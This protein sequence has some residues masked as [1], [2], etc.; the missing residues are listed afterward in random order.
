MKVYLETSIN[1]Y[2]SKVEELLL[3]DEANNN[4]MLGLLER[5]RNNIGI[6]TNGIR[7]GVVEED[8]EVIYAFMQTPPN[9]WILAKID[10][11]Q[12]NIIP[13]I[14]QFLFTN[15]YPVPGVLGPLKQV[16]EFVSLW[17]EVSGKQADLS[18]K[19]LIYQLDSVRVTPDP[20]GE[21][22]I[23]EDTHIPLA[24]RWLY[25]FAQ[26]ARMPMTKQD[27]DSMAVS[28]IQKQSLFLWKMGDELVSMANNS[29]RTKNGSTINAVFTPDK[30]KRKGYA[31]SIVAALSQKLLDD[32]FTFC[33]LYTDADN[34]TSNSIYRKIGYYIVG[35]SVEY[36]FVS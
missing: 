34:P 10:S 12:K 28:F 6:Y 9:K 31:T 26:E 14:V 29:R 25:Q 19:Q 2:L 15:K 20:R 8:G 13:A 4:L 30:Y 17:K 27:A 11:V 7:L 1:N 33:S 36:Y 21:L 22:M 32:G 16:E 35:E 18:M 3:K 24:K 5:G 23:A